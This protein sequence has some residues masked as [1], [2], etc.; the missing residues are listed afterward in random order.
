M[1]G[2]LFLGLGNSSTSGLSGL[3]CVSS[4]ERTQG[5][6][7]GW[8]TTKGRVSRSV[9]AAAGGSSVWRSRRLLWVWVGVLKG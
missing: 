3:T 8:V 1:F 7:S 6:F 2:N 5:D 9:K 4:G